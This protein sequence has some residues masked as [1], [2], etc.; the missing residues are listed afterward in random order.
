MKPK[1]IQCE[2][3]SAEWH[4]LRNKMISATN[5][6]PI[7]GISPWKTALMLYEEK[8]GYR[9]P[10]KLN[11][12]MTEGMLLEEHA[13]SFFNKQHNTD[14]QPI[15]LQH[16]NINYLMSSLDGINSNGEILE[17]KCGKGSHELAKQGIIP[18]YYL[19][20]VQCQIFCSNVSEAH[21]FSYRSDEDNVLLK[22]QRD[23][24][25]IEKMLT[26]VDI[27]YRNLLNFTAP[28][29]CDRD[30]ANIDTRE[31]RLHT[32]VWKDT[33]RQIKLLE[34]REEALRNELIAMCDGKS[35]QGNGVR[36]SKQVTK[37]RVDFSKINIL[38]DINLDEYRSKPVTS[39][40]FTEVKG[41]D[42]VE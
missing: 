31:W 18:D 12:K 34:A 42:A 6:A 16:G 22:V 27:F 13:R 4:S 29:P 7:M 3:G 33:K 15:V 5:I 30:F 41:Q 21:Y 37:G 19:C 39:F 38:K 2:Q 40:R 11:E 8:L 17:I 9:E 28:V 20:Q 26:S 23:D 1:I 35:S 10:E 36:V 24:E 14:F 32:E 25:F